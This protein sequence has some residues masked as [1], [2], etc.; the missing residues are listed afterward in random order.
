VFIKFPDP[1]LANED[2]L[3]AV[4]G[5]LEAEMLLSAYQQGIFPW[6]VKPITWWSPDPRAIFEIDT[7]SLSSRM[8]RAFRNSKLSY[9]LN[10]CFS[11]VIKS[12][13]TKGSDRNSTWIS[14]EFI[15]AYCRLHELG[16]AHSA[17]AWLDGELVGGI[18]GVAIGG[19]FA[20]ESMFHTVT[21]SST[22]CLKFLMEHLKSKGF[23]LFDSQVASPHTYRLGVTD[24]SRREYL[25]RLR[26]ALSLKC[27]FL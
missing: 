17:E 2:G 24:I 18:Y 11:E 5:S 19:F 16:F 7:F 8:E 12:C 1:E 9:S 27:K 3:L 25:E 23:V 6:S 20:G 10:T 22:L 15:K 21:N 4:G 26:F 13:A 14:R